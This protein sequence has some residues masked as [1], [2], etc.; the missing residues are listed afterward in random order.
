MVLQMEDCIDVLKLLYP[1][2]DVLFLF[3][4]L[5]SQHEDGLNGEKMS[6][7]YGGKQS[8]FCTSLIKQERGYLGRFPCTF[9]PGDMQQMVFLPDG[10]GPFWM[11][12][13]QRQSARLDIEIQGKV[14]K[15]IL[16]KKNLRRN[17]LSKVLLHKEISQ[18]SSECAL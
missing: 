8:I 2:N 11:M 16:Q 13:E 18:T 10:E 4:H 17:L 15:G 1:Q 9:N 14:I 12:S 6:K 7:K 3:D 5:C